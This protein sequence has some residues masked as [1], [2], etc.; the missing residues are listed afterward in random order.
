MIQLKVQGL[1]FRC[2]H[3]ALSLEGKG[4]PRCEC[5]MHTVQVMSCYMFKPTKP[6]ITKVASGY[7]KCLRFGP[8]FLAAREQGIELFE[9]HLSLK[10]LKQDKVY[11]YWK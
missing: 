9:G 8:T 5:G 10:K 2:E 7:K 3:R 1:C 6:I 4:E 11:L